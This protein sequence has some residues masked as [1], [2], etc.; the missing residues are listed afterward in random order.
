[1]KIKED[2]SRNIFVS[3][4][5]LK[6]QLRNLI[7]AQKA[8]EEMYLNIKIPKEQDDE[9]KL[10]AIRKEYIKEN[11]VLILGA[12]VSAPYNLPD[13]NMLLQKLLIDTFITETKENEESSKM[14]SK[15]FTILFTNSPLISARYLSEY[16]KENKNGNSFEQAIKEVLYED[17]KKEFI[18]DT[19]KEIVQYCISPGKT[20]TLD[21]II[22]YNYDNILENALDNSQI[23][24]QYKSIYTVGM[25]ADYGELPIYHVHGY[26]PNNIELEQEHKVTLSEN[27]YHK[28]YNDIYSWDNLI[29][30][31][32]FREK[33]CLFIGN[34]FTDPNLR[35]LLDVAMLQRGKG[36]NPHY[37]IK[38]K[39]DENDINTR[40]TNIL[41][42][43]NNLLREKQDAQLELGQTIENLIEVMEKFE[44]FDAKSFGV[45]V[46]WINDYSEIPD[47]LKRIR[48][49]K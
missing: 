26:L 29:Q 1:M 17:V 30:I 25:N 37:I 45:E 28:Q 6:G 18:S 35:R 41:N 20:P 34:S 31:N 33:T 7:F 47:I 12:G 23:D 32:K 13:W 4:N 49:N 27:I 11:L 3:G 8:L 39:Y 36:D 46:I 5:S 44:E 16:Y 42:S 19:M 9:S 14:L 15:L 21:S 48:T 40:L 10:Q 38:K 2:L 43:E 24:I 22:T